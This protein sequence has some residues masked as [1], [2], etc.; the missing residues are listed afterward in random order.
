MQR[1]VFITL[2]STGDIVPVIRLAEEAVKRGHRASLL[3]SHHWKDLIES[4]GIEW[5]SIP[6]HGDRNELTSLMAQYSRI[7][8]PLRLL[9]AMYRDLDRWQDEI[10]P[11]LEDSLDGA[12]A[13]L[14]SYLFPLYQPIAARRGIPSASIHFCPNTSFSDSH[15]PED[16]PQL[17]RLFP[18]RIRNAWNR[19]LTTIGDR[20]VT[21]KINPTISRPELR[22]KSW[23]RSPADLS[24][25]LAPPELYR[26]RSEDL[27]DRVV[28][29]GF[30]PSGFSAESHETPADI[31]NAPLINFGSVN[32]PSMAGE[33]ANLYR[34]WPA[35]RPLTIQKGWADPPPPPTGSR[36]RIIGP[37]D[38]GRLFPQASMIIHHGG[39]GTTTSSFLAGKPQII[40]P[41]F[42]DQPYWARTVRSHGCGLSLRQQGWGR[43]LASA[44]R[45]IESDPAFRHSAENFAG[46]QEGR[47]GATKAIDAVESRLSGSSPR[48]AAPTS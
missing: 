4:R 19:H 11:A 33:F 23:L 28:F 42:A 25:I 36:I 43:K 47:A 26:G 5:V 40:V 8:N 10:I 18:Q 41:H 6:P 30:V 44:I 24:L 15:P 45:R 31:E 12:D 29:A 7:R 38:H 32:H 35:D 9:R 3:A 27:P 2:G 20:H 21:G 14:Y 17:P 13:L 1:L 39:A 46:Q 37:A 48:G 22:L 16:I 34:S